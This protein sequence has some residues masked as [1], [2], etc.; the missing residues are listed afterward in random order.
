MGVPVD[1]S[2]GLE[3]GLT[4][5]A[6]RRSWLSQLLILCERN[7]KQYTRRTDTIFMNFC[8]TVLVAVFIGC[9]IWHVMGDT[10]ADVAKIPPSLFFTCVTQGIFASL[11]CVNSFPSERAVMLRERQAGSYW[12]SSY[13]MAKVR[14][15]KLLSHAPRVAGNIYRCTAV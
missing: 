13:F 3:K 5:S 12:V 10:Q 2:M 8:A 14:R 7:L 4:A 6:G 15:G 9:G 11:Q 1:L